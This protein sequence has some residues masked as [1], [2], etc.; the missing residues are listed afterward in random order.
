[1]VHDAGHL[2]QRRAVR[3]LAVV[4]GQPLSAGEVAGAEHLVQRRQ[5]V[6]VRALGQPRRDEREHGDLGGVRRRLERLLAQLL[7]LVRLL[8]RL[9]RC[10]G[11]DIGAGLAAGEQQGGERHCCQHCCSDVGH[12]GC[13][14]IDLF[15]LIFVDLLKALSLMLKLISTEGPINICAAHCVISH[16]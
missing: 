13:F 4:D 6:L 9:G 5:G 2:A 14:S 12:L 1:V 3:L 15:L 7:P 16:A 10:H 8:A 11:R